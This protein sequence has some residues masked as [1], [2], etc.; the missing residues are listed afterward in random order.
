MLHVSKEF[1][2]DN[3]RMMVGA[4]VSA[5]HFQWDNAEKE[6]EWN[7]ARLPL[8]SG[9]TAIIQLQMI[10]KGLPMLA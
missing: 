4:S 2:L 3:C 9:A 8:P 5:F 1:M 6:T 7:E 10:F